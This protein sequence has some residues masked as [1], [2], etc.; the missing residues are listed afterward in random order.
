MKK[1]TLLSR[2]FALVEQYASLRNS[3][4][5]EMFN[6]LQWFSHSS[7]ASICTF[8]NMGHPLRATK[9]PAMTITPPRACITPTDS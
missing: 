1:R 6:A 7:T 3:E 9:M 8:M 5:R 4:L 2:L